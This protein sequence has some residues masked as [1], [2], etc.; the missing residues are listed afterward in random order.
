MHA[1]LHVSSSKLNIDILEINLGSLKFCLP[2]AILL[3]ER[4]GDLKTVHFIF[5]PHK[6]KSFYFMMGNFMQ[7]LT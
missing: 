7:S 1:F 5:V 3:E 4:Y 6:G 2:F